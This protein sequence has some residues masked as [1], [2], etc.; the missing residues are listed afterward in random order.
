MSLL[1]V[2]TTRKGDG[3]DG[4]VADDLLVQDGL[5]IFT[6]H[7]LEVLRAAPE[8]TVVVRDLGPIREQATR[9]ALFMETAA[10]GGVR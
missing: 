8:E 9:G 1:L 10:C 6:R 2:V 3:L 5:R 7:G 4:V